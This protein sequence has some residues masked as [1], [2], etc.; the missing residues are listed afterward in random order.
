MTDATHTERVR[1]LVGCM[2]CGMGELQTELRRT[3][4]LQRSNA[5]ASAARCRFYRGGQ[6]GN[7]TCIIEGKRELEGESR[8]GIACCQHRYGALERS[9]GRPRDDD[10]NAI[11]SSRRALLGRKRHLVCEARV[12]GG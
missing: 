2:C 10:G 8:R 9:T 5:N 7:L 12:C 4:Q 3:A 6:L 11:R 1:Y